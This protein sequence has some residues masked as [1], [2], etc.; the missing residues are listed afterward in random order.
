MNILLE[1]LPTEYDGY[2]VNTDFRIGIQINLMM[3]DKE[4]TGYEKNIL[5]IELLFGNEDGSVRDH[6]KDIKDVLNWLM[7][8]WYT[9][10]NTSSKKHERLI[11]YNIDQWRIYSD[12]IQIYHINLNEIESMHFWEFQAL[13]WNMPDE[14]S[15]FLKVISIRRKKLKPKMSKTEKEAITKAKAIY[16]LEQPNEKQ[17]SDEDKSKIDSFDKIQEERRKKQEIAQEF[18]KK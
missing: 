1:P 3:E 18:L 5:L 9:D 12:F 16:A 2:E 6:P 7:T 13:L 11:D 14:Q 15:S 8:G 10:K 17:F 4:L